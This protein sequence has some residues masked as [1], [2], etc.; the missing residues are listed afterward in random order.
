[1]L[2]ITGE[3]V[4]LSTP[5][6][7][8]SVYFELCAEK[9]TTLC[10][11][12]EIQ[13]KLN[14]LHIHNHSENFYLHFLNK[15]YGYKL[16]NM[17]SVQ[18]NVEGIDLCD[19]TNQI[20][21]QVSSTATKAKLQSALAKDLSL[22]SGYSFRFMSIARDAAS[23]RKHTYKNPHKLV[24]DPPVDIHDVPSLLTRIQGLEINAQQEIY[25]FLKSELD[26]VSRDKF[27]ETN[28]AGIINVLSMEDLQDGYAANAPIPFD[29]DKKISTNNL[30]SAAFLVEDYKIHHHRVSR[31]YEE[32]NKAGKNKSNSVLNSLRTMYAKL[33]VNH[34]GDELFFKVIDMAVEKIQESANYTEM[35][36]DELEHYVNLLT[37][38]AFIRCKI[39]RNPF[40]ESH[41]AA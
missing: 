41:A 1:M 26:P 20:V 34:S 13:G 40:E 19:K 28:L 7:K 4:K 14:L 38:D 39:F 3:I 29:V 25:N 8:R 37:V 21:V 30:I 24:F 12:I 27:T 11:R 35:P 9:L 16:E 22:F 15:L 23:L 10:T 5:D 17:N 2:R 33:S 32:F 6:M 31:L 18:Q 36:L